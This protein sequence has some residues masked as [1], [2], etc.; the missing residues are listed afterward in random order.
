MKAE[1]FGL[2]ITIYYGNMAVVFLAG[3]EGQE[4]GAHALKSG[5][6]QQGFVH[7]LQQSD[8][9]TLHFPHTSL[10]TEYVKLSQETFLI[11][12]TVTVY[13]LTEACYTIF[14]NYSNI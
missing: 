12:S 5:L 14:Y 10:L 2:P 8:Q 13:L 3:G 7:T 1:Q 6:N 4:N 9:F 11:G